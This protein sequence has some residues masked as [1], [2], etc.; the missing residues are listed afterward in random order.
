MLAH[1]RRIKAY[2]DQNKQAPVGK[3]VRDLAPVIRGWTL[4]YRHA[5]SARTFQYADHRVWQMLWAWA[6]RRH[7]TKEQKMGQGPLL[8]AD[9]DSR[10]WNFA[11]AIAAGVG[12]APLVQ[13]HQ[14]RPPHEGQGAHQ[15]PGPGR[16]ALLG[17]AAAEETGGPIPLQATTGT[18]AH[19]RLRLRRMRRPVRPG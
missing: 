1:L 11:D 3:V 19:P 15:S 17:R 7:P 13:R 5:C 14:D 12:H 8:Q 9:P 16:P 4:Y 6:R 18:P 10:V 2:L